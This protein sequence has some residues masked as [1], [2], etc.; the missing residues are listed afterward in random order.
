MPSQFDLVPC[1]LPFRVA[2][3]WPSSTN[4]TG[5]ELELRG[6]AR[7]LRDN[8]KASAAVGLR[9]SKT[10]ILGSTRGEVTKKVVVLSIVC[11]AP[12]IFTFGIGRVLLVGA[13]MA[14]DGAAFHS[15]KIDKRTIQKLVRSAHRAGA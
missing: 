12:F 10:A 14:D 3:A 4:V 6:D 2:R 15:R 1:G 7:K 9:L 8:L 11:C 5:T 13:A